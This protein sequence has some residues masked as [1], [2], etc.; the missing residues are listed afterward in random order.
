MPLTKEEIIQID[1]YIIRYS[2]YGMSRLLIDYSINKKKSESD[3]M[4]LLQ[5]ISKQGVKARELLINSIDSITIDQILKDRKFKVFGF[6]LDLDKN[7]ELLKECLETTLYKISCIASNG[8]KEKQALLFKA[9]DKGLD[10]NS[11]YLKIGDPLLSASI[12][13]QPE[14][15]FNLVDK[16]K[17][18][19]NFNVKDTLSY[20]PLHWAVKNIKKNKKGEIIRI[21]K[22]RRIIRTLLENGADPNNKDIFGK[23][24]FDWAVA[25][26][27]IETAMLLSNKTKAEIVNDEKFNQKFDRIDNDDMTDNIIQYLTLKYDYMLKKPSTKIKGEKIKAIVQ[28]LESESYQ[29]K[30]EKWAPSLITYGVCNGW[31]FLAALKA[32][33]G[34]LVIQEF[35]KK[36]A[37]LSNWDG[38][39]ESLVDR[40]LI[41]PEWRDK[42]TNLDVLFK[43]LTNDIYWFHQQNQTY[44]GLS[45]NDRVK[46]LKAI[47]NEDIGIVSDFYLNGLTVEE[48]KLVLESFK[49]ILTETIIDAYNI[50]HTVSFIQDAN[51]HIRYLDPNIPHELPK[52][53][54]FNDAV[55]ATDPSMV[56]RNLQ[57]FAFFHTKPEKI[58]N[59]LRTKADKISQ[60]LITRQIVNNP[61]RMNQWGL[62]SILEHAS[63][64]NSPH[65]LRNLLHHPV[66][67]SKFIDMN[68]EFNLFQ[69]AFNT[70]IA[71]NSFDSIYM[72]YKENLINLIGLNAAQFEAL[73]RAG[74]LNEDDDLIKIAKDGLSK[75]NL[76]PEQSALLAFDYKGH[77]AKA[78]VKEAVIEL[79]KEII[80]FT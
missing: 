72:L 16:Y 62:K 56:S 27:D 32:F 57:G 67:R 64:S 12:S 30:S 69:L 46:Q 48:E 1:D 20:T 45:F 21:K 66:L 23:T 59:E 74:N 63:Y 9:I 77:A 73:L 43:E 19:I 38:K 44:A 33:K 51:D 65:M 37:L 5:Y 76:T 54:N 35:Y 29:K 18:K 25:N 79:D 58:T 60:D 15:F 49:P 3:F 40:N 80:R 39:K 36:C 24:P 78:A 71:Y 28:Q 17:S 8:T 70:A 75:L 68:P 26:G 22:D 6:L 47:Y 7:S 53:N 13:W 10:I 11:P 41:P 52:Y 42:Y 4:E 55:N 61:E 14:L 34:D 50:G 31:S 2:V